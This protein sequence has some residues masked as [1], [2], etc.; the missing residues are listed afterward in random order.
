MHESNN[1][2]G[3]LMEGGALRGLFTAGVIDVFLEQGITFP[4][5]V[6]VSAGA[7]FGCN[8]KSHQPGRV[9]RYNLAQCKNPDYCSVRSLIRTGDL[10]GAELC[11]HTIPKELDPFD[12][13]AFDRDP[14]AFYVV[15]TDVETGEPVYHRCDRIADHTYDWIRASASMPFVARPVE[16]EGRSYLDGG[17]A[18]AIPIRFLLDLG[19]LHNVA[20]L[21][22]PRDYI[23][24]ASRMP[25]SLSPLMRSHPRLRAVME[26]RHIAYARSRSLVFAREAA[27]MTVVICPERPLPIDRVTHDPEKLH[28]TYTLGRR[29]AK[30]AL[31]AVRAMLAG[32]SGSKTEKETISNDESNA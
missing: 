19:Y 30:A 6:G 24:E 31:P 7:C 16:I 8:I 5:A 14:M 28:E 20:V 12:E 29:A 13:A 23:K 26:Q 32:E 9:L 27:G 15:C 10:F 2:V 22:R 17:I 1:P 21:T 18:D 4:A 3:L 25:L 11:Y